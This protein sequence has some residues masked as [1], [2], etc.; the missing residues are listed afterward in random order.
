V[1]D[2]LAPYEVSRFEAY[3][4]TIHRVGWNAMDAHDSLRSA[5]KSVVDAVAEWIGLDDADPRITWLYSQEI[6][7][8]TEVVQ[9]RKGAVR[10]S[11]NRL[12]V[13]IRV[14]GEHDA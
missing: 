4:V 6:T 9:T 11:V 13:V 5:S 14:R 12:R 3:E 1:R 7:R 2:A 10:Q 8:E